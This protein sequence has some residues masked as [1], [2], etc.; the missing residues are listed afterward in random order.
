MN[1]FLIIT[2]RFVSPESLTQSIRA[3]LNDLSD[4]GAAQASASPHAPLH[5]LDDARP[6][7]EHTN[8]SNDAQS[9][10]ERQP[11]AAPRRIVFE[12][13]SS[14][15][16]YVPSELDN[17]PSPLDAITLD[18]LALPMQS[19]GDADIDIFI[20]ELGAVDLVTILNSTLPNDMMEVVKTS[21]SRA[22][23]SPGEIN[24]K[25]VKSQIRIH[26]SYDSRY[27]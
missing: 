1:R 7:A 20:N 15:K 10:L 5:H 27:R 2:N 17:H 13:E 23:Y 14:Q 9:D 24:G 16:Y 8:T 22:V 26:I 6:L 11:T 25:Q 18:A 4:A 12:S 21:F 19:S 3:K